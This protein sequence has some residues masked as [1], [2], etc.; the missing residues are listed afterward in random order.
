LASTSDATG[1]GKW[2]K[3]LLAQGAGVNASDKYGETP[4]HWPAFAPQESG[5]FM[6]KFLLENGADVNAISLIG[7]SP[8]RDAFSR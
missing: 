2:A 7:R 3:S 5:L 4:L 1:S 8:L 6:V